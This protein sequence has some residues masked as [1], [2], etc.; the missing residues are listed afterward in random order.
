MD[1]AGAIDRARLN[2][3]VLGLAA[4]GAAVHA[5][6]AADG[7]GNA[8]QE[9]QSGDARLLR[10]ARD[11][12]VGHRSAG[13]NVET[14]DRDLA[15]AAAEPDHHAGHAAVAHD[16]IGAEPDDGDGNLGRQICQK[17]TEVV[18]VLRHE[19]NL[20]RPADAKPGQLGERLVRQQ[21]AAQL[22]H[23]C[24]QRGGDIGKAHPAPSS[25]SSHAASTSCPT[26]RV[27]GPSVRACVRSSR[28]SMP[29]LPSSTVWPTSQ[30]SNRA[31]S[32]SR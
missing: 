24:A 5:Q 30:L 21:P 11:L 4:I 6:R 3:R 29:A 13:A 15:E 2:Q 18:L 12:D 17:I 7:A 23:F 9:R 20:R 32:V 8:A 19:Q 25:L 22:R 27:A 10:R 14:F 16:Q 26:S 1:A 31:G 28:G